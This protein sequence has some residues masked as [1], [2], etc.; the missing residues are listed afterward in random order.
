M[1]DIVSKASLLRKLES[2]PIDQFFNITSIRNFI[3][4]EPEAIVRCGECKYRYQDGSGCDL[5]M[6]KGYSA[7]KSDW[8]CSKAERKEE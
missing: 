6:F 3:N 5:D 7:I 8:F 2:V 1:N 4:A